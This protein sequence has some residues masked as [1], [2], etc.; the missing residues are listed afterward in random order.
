M[1]FIQ[2]V[3]FHILLAIIIR[4]EFRVEEKKKKEK[5]RKKKEKK[6]KRHLLFQKRFLSLFVREYSRWMDS[7]RFTHNDFKA[8][9]Y[10]GNIFLVITSAHVWSLACTFPSRNCNNSYHRQA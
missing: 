1:Y 7:R 5:K 6:K 4:N 8:V 2:A 9:I 10:L 3:T